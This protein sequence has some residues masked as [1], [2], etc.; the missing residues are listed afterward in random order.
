M[1]WLLIWIT[2]LLPLQK[3]RLLLSKISVGNHDCWRNFD[4]KTVVSY[5]LVGKCLAIDFKFSSAILPAD[6]RRDF[7]WEVNLKTSIFFYVHWQS[8]GKSNSN[9]YVFVGNH[10]QSVSIWIFFGGIPSVFHRQSVQIF[11]KIFTKIIP[12][13]NLNLNAI[14]HYNHQ[15]TLQNIN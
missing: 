8:V 12:K 10:R 7:C 15:H 2:V 4:R 3:N 5:L 13:P 9:L 11:K 14:F 1:F 6:L